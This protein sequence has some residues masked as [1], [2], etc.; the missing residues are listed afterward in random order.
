MHYYILKTFVS[1]NL[2]IKRNTILELK[3]KQ[4]GRTQ[5]LLYAKLK[6]RNFAK[7]IHFN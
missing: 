5:L 7:N 1:A 2:V 3:A 6:A 4:E